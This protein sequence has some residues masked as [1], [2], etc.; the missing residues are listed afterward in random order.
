MVFNVILSSGILLNVI[1]LSSIL[2]N[3]ILSSGILLNV[4]LSSGIL[5][6][7]TLVASLVS[8]Y[9]AFNFAKSHSDKLSANQLIVI[10]LNVVAPFLAA[11]PSILYCNSKPVAAFATLYFTR[12]L[13]MGRVS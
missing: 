10:L 12:N 7:V 9:L 6:N 3:V 11:Y 4:I 2:L 5:L 13:Q 1:L 8:F